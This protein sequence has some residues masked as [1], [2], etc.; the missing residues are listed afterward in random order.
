MTRTTATLRCR[1]SA[2]ISTFRF[3][4][5][6]AFQSVLTG[7]SLWPGTAVRGQAGKLTVEATEVPTP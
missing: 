1:P 6:A 4:H 5:F 2:L 7:D 3:G